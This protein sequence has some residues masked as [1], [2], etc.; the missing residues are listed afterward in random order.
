MGVCAVGTAAL[1][2]ADTCIVPAEHAVLCRDLRRARQQLQRSDRRGQ[3]GRRR[4][5]Q[6]G[7][8]GRVRPGH[9]CTARWAASP[10]S[11]TRPRPP[12]PATA[13][14]TTATAD[15]RG[16]SR[17]RRGVQ[18]R[19]A[20]RVRGGHEALPGGAIACVRR[21]RGPAPRPATASTTTATAASTTATRAAARAATPGM[22][23]VCAPGTRHCIAGNVDLQ[24]EPVV[25]ARGLQQPG[26][27]LQRPGRRGQSGRRW[28]CSTGE[29]GV[30]ARGTSSARAGRW[31]ASGRP[32][33]RAE[34]CNSGADEDCDGNVDELSDCVLCP[35]AN[36]VANGVPDQ[37][38]EGAPQGH[39][40]E[41]QAPDAGH[42]RAAG[43]GL[44]RAGH[45]GGQRAADRRRGLY[46]EATI[47]AGSFKRSGSGRHFT[48][49]DRT[50]AT[51]ASR[52][53][54]SRS[55]ATA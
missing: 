5:M 7:P 51:A 21:T 2:R 46:Y 37:E 14:T 48:F 24:A 23:G 47:P 50:G 33:R 40:G 13:S 25:D 11:A 28:C 6:H 32:D 19:P 38:D 35:P 36:T 8:A 41:R 12:R 27:Q 22:P 15:R 26:R 42:L 10:A 31:A 44:D 1:V 53:R 20:G 43:T 54:S 55:R 4:R 9:D 16:R 49:S 17:R 39:A 45:Q 3:P 30:C 18:H 52:R 29:L 34:I